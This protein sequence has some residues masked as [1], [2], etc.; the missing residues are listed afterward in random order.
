MLVLTN[1]ILDMGE[2]G[3]PKSWRL[4]ESLK[5][6]AEAFITEKPEFEDFIFSYCMEIGPMIRVQTMLGNI[7]DDSLLDYINSLA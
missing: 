7:Y 4:K 5:T 2:T 1:Y 6:V 3:H